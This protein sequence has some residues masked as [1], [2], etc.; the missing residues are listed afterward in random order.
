MAENHR[1]EPASNF[2]QI[3]ELDS[4]VGELSAFLYALFELASEPSADAARM[5]AINAL[6]RAFNDHLTKAQDALT[7]LQKKGGDA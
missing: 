3:N 4:A 5:E 2:D 7:A 1:R 6:L